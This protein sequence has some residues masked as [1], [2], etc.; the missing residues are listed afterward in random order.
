MSDHPVFVS[1]AVPKGVYALVVKERLD[2][3]RQKTHVT[4]HTTK[5]TVLAWAKNTQRMFPDVEVSVL[6]APL[7][8][9]PLGLPA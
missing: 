3:G 4:T 7:D 9:E 1:H 5:A 8:W 6:E 2:G